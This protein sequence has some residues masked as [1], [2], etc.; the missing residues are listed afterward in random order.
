MSTVQLA[1]LELGLALRCT[2]GGHAVAIPVGSAGQV[3]EFEAMAVPF[4]REA[5][6]GIG[7]HR[8]GLLLT[9]G[10]GRAP[11]A[12]E[13]RTARGVLLDAPGL[14]CACAF[15]VSELGG[16]ATIRRSERRRKGPAWWV[17]AEVEGGGAVGWLDVPLLVQSLLG[18]PREGRG[19]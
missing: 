8:G 12:G 6:R 14:P 9:L 7:I 18:R 13:Q 19:P 3:I 15:E 1:S 10:L 2:S 16:L 5:F 17:D 4:A 11:G